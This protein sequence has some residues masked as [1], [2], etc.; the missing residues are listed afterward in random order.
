MKINPC[1]PS[2]L[3]LAISC[4]S[5]TTKPATEPV[6]AIDTTKAISH[7]GPDPKNDS[8][9][10]LKTHLSG[11]TY[12][13]GSFILF[14]EPNGARYAE[15]EK[16]AEG[17]AGDADTDFGIGISNTRDSVKKNERYKDIEVLTSTSRYICV[18][19]CKNGPLIIDRD[20]VSYGFILSAKGRPIATTYNSVHSGDYLG[21]L[22]E[23]FSLR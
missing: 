14:L 5:A 16:E 6:K 21:E 10:I 3:V 4:H 9:V 13:A 2:L 1:L 19:D 8:A 12:A 20:S 17:D 7:P 15:L 23:Y 22:N 18:K 11:T